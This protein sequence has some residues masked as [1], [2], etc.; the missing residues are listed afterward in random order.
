MHITAYTC[1]R[2]RLIGWNWSRNNTLFLNEKVSLF[3]YD[4][5]SIILLFIYSS[6]EIFSLQGY[7]SYV[8]FNK[9]NISYWLN[10]DVKVFLFMSVKTRIAH[11]LGYLY[12]CFLSFGSVHSVNWVIWTSFV[13]A[14]AGTAAVTQKSRTICIYIY[15]YCLLSLYSVAGYVSY[16]VC[17]YIDACHLY[18]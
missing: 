1:I 2:K 11:T 3:I 6:I 14:Y 15:M 13:R 16:S 12:S 18:V 10:K 9:N 5:L 7:S 4:K 17:L 8:R